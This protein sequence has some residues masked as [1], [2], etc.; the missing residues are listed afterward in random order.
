MDKLPTPLMTDF[1]SA[2]LL[3]VLTIGEIQNKWGK[4]RTAIIMAILKG[5][6]VARQV[7]GKQGTWLIAKQSVISRWGQ[8]LS[9]IGE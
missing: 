9:P 5:D 7:G 8:P 6:L 1:Q 4:S 2:C 3:E